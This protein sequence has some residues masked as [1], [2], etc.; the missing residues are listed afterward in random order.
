[1]QQAQGQLYASPIGWGPTVS[2]VNPL[3]AYADTGHWPGLR[4]DIS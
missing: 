3:I 4:L 1:M 2:F